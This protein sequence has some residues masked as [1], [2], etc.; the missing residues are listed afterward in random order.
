[1]KK[2]GINKHRFLDGFFSL[3]ALVFLF[4]GAAFAQEAG[5]R[6]REAANSTYGNS[7]K[8]QKRM[9]GNTND[10]LYEQLPTNN[11][12]NTYAVEAKVLANITPDEYVVTFA[13]VQEGPTPEACTQAID[14]RINQ[15]K[16]ELQ[17]LG[18]ASGDMFVDFVTQTPVYDYKL[19]RDSAKAAT[20]TEYEAGFELK[21]NLMI[22]YTQRDLLD[23]MTQAAAKFQ[24]YDLVKVDFIVRNPAALREKLR[25]E[26]MNVIKRKLAESEKTLGIKCRPVAIE[27][28]RYSNEEPGDLYRS[29]TAYE[30]SDVS[31]TGRGTLRVVKQRKPVTY[32]FE[33]VD[34][35]EFDVIIN[36]AITSP[37]AQYGLFLRVRCDPE[38]QIPITTNPAAPR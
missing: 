7:Q 19:K 12:F 1:M 26:A 2:H 34:T 21:K 36:P 9:F 22:R 8:S 5:N 15:F 35:G 25:T 31:S 17:K 32:Y 37:V 30:S 29:Y 3:F 33:G 20:A 13:L 27:F 18:I 11:T 28:E 4:T 23:A 24:I 16:A 38:V 10:Y 14:G 6:V